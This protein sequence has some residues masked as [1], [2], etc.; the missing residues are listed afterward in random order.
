M[1]TQPHS[2]PH[3]VSLPNTQ[4]VSLHTHIS[5]QYNWHHH[6]PTHGIHI[7]PYNTIYVPHL[8][9]QHTV[10]TY[11]HIIT[12]MLHAKYNRPNRHPIHETPI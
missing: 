3:V 11:P 8:T 6:M 9:M 4:T 2:K 7:P 1:L 10:Y 5:I 12:Y